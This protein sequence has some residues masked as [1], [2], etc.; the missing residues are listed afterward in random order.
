MLLHS[1]HNITKDDF[2]SGVS[3]LELMNQNVE[4]LKEALQ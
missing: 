2:E 1:C 4:N 3:Y